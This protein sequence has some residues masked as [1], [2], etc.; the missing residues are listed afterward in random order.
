VLLRL[1][2][3]LADSGIAFEERHHEPTL[4]SQDA[5]RVR[6]DPLEQGGKALL[7][8]AGESFRL[9]VMS[10]ALRLDSGAIKRQLRVKKVRFATPEELHALTG[11]VPGSVPPFGHPVL[12]FDLH[13][14]PS[15]TDNPHI[16]FNAG[17][18]TDSMTLSTSDYVEVARP[19]IFRFAK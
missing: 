1:R 9:F 2:T 5:A 16:S 12:P 19:D 6:G 11:L 4:T 10:A 3:V 15:I 14:D 8:K 18:L 17:S 7:I 13:V